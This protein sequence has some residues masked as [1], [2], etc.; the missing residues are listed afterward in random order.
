MRFHRGED[1]INTITYGAEKCAF[2]FKRLEEFQNKFGYNN[3][4][5]SKAEYY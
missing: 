4:E 2:I 5:I 3:R 1:S